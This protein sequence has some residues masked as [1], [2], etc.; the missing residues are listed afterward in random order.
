MDMVVSRIRV[1][2]DNFIETLPKTP[3]D[4]LLGSG[5]GL[6]PSLGSGS[7]GGGIQ[8]RD[9]LIDSNIESYVEMDLMDKIYDN[10]IGGERGINSSDDDN[11]NVKSITIDGDELPILTLNTINDIDIG[12]P[13]SSSSYNAKSNSIMNA[14]KKVE[15]ETVPGTRIGGPPVTVVDSISKVNIFAAAVRALS[16][17]ASSLS[18]THPPSGNVNPFPYSNFTPRPIE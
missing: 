5:I 12:I 9:L 16:N 1:L 15:K 8:G 18:S 6:G 17:R 2:Q 4:L 14:I 13:F 3:G 11:H 10:T 7:G